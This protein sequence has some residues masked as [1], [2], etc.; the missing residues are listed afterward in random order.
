[1]ERV[2]HPPPTMTSFP[3][4]GGSNQVCR[5]QGHSSVALP[6]PCHFCPGRSLCFLLASPTQWISGNK[7]SVL[8]LSAESQR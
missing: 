7:V 5:A 4:P 6:L 2:P 1:M 8:P 3:D